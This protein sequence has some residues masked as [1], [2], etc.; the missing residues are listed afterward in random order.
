MPYLPETAEH[1]IEPTDNAVDAVDTV[2]QSSTSSRDAKCGKILLAWVRE[3]YL[4][5][6]NYIKTSRKG[7]KDSELKA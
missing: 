6:Q 5:L 2:S 4:I 1:F 7:L 3:T